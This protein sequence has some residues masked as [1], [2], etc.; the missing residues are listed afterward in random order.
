MNTT[1][2]VVFGNAGH[3]KDTF[4]DLL[5][6]YLPGH[7]HRHAFADGFKTATSDLLGVPKGIVYGTLEEK[8][9]TMVY[10]KSVR[11]WL[12]WFGTEVGRDGIDKDIW[13]HRAADKAM[14]S[15]AQFSVISDG[16]FWN[17]L[18]ALRPYVAKAGIK[19]VNILIERP[20]AD[21]LGGLP[22]TR[23]NLF[24][25]KWLGKIGIKVE[26]MHPS[27]WEVI[28]M[29]NPPHCKSDFDH[30]IFNGGSLSDLERKAWELSEVL[31]E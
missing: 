29:R 15:G 22:R 6:K 24:K 12:Q 23:W 1:I 4:S 3:G 17:E 16:R 21:S 26:L 30:V 5:A 20:D 10:G 27:E 7:V 2:I 28:E 19:V 9:G 14:T 11:R 13:V 25:A 18:Q 31:A 8:N